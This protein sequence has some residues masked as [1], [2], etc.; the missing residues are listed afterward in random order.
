MSWKADY[1]TELKQMDCDVKDNISEMLQDYD[2]PDYET[3]E[4]PTSA[5]NSSDS[6]LAVIFRDVDE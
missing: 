3:V 5:L 6:Q 2:P 4:A 1:K